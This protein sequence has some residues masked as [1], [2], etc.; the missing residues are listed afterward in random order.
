MRLGAIALLA[1]LLSLGGCVGDDDPS[2]LSIHNVQDD[3]TEYEIEI[4][5][6][7]S[8]EVV[9]RYEGTLNASGSA[10][11]NDVLDSGGVYLINVSAGRNLTASYQWDVSERGPSEGS[12]II[13][14]IEESELMIS[15][16]DR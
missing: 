15:Q 10:A 8:G 3:A 12:V 14:R 2:D 1:L 9:T 7:A 4:S 16:D 13:I 5:V 6:Q 11:Y